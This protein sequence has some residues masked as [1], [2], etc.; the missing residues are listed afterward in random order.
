MTTR[1][2]LVTGASGGIGQAI[3]LQLAAQ[4]LHVWIHYYTNEVS[5]DSLVQQIHDQGGKASKIHFNVADGVQCQQV[6]EAL[7][8]EQGLFEILVHNAGYCDDAPFAGMT[9]EQWTG[10]IDAGLNS[11]YYVTRPLIMPMIRN[12]WGRIVSISSVAAIH[13]SHG[14]SNYAAAKAGLIGASRSLARELASRGICVNVVAP[15][16]IQ[17]P[18]IESVSEQQIKQTVPMK[19]TGTPQEVAN[20]VAFLCSESVSYVTG[21]VIHVSGGVA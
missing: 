1:K 8:E 21:E 13:G 12:R 20:V 2:A 6:L 9:K 4:G 10:V 19:R 14:Q 18:M 16:F 5:A 15:G 17:T 7:I 11:F 3:A